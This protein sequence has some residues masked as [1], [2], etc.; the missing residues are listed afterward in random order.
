MT[1]ANAL[2]FIISAVLV[3]FSLVIGVTKSTLD[4]ENPEP[5]STMESMDVVV[6]GSP[7]AEVERHWRVSLPQVRRIH[8][9]HAERELFASPRL[10]PFFL[11]VTSTMRCTSPLE[12][13]QLFC[14]QGVPWVYEQRG[15]WEPEP[16][17]DRARVKY[18][19][20]T[21]IM[22]VVIN[23]AALAAMRAELGIVYSVRF[24][25][26]NYAL[27][28]GLARLNSNL[29]VHVGRFAKA[30]RKFQWLGVVE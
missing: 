28:H 29:S 7:D 9:I 12:W 17:H 25:Y 2:T 4:V 11:L 10:T 5:V 8:F 26:P 30:Q 3:A 13:A 14:R 18:F 23:R 22:P 15:T 27:Q 24:A 21:S 20:S 19:Q 6:V 1:N 16:V